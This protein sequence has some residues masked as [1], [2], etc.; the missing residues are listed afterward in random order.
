[1]KAVNLLLRHDDTFMALA[2]NEAEK[3]FQKGEVPVGAVIVYN[4]Q[5]VARAHNQ[6]ELLKD[7]TAHAEIL[8][9]TQASNYLSDWRLNEATLY[10]TKEPCTMC[11]GA[12]VNCK[13]STVVYGA[14]DPRSGAAG[15]AIDITG[16]KGNLH[17][18]N[19]KSGV[20]KED[21]LNILQKFFRERRKK[22]I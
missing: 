11:A 17:R 13:L 9:I 1:M 5:I 7:A 3:A 22:K 12:M 14:E 20:L 19:V 8:A 15:S 10:V 2:L 6:I 16:F 18:V 21:C 4:G